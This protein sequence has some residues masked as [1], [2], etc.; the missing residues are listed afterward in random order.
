VACA[1]AAADGIPAPTGVGLTVASGDQT[2]LYGV[3]TYWDSVCVCGPLAERGLDVR[4]Y[5]QIAYWRGTQ[6]PSE[7]P[8]LWEGSVT[9][10]LRWMGPSVGAATV[11]AEIGLAFGGLSK[12]GSTKRRKLR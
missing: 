1:N 6:R 2:T 9:P 4:I 7:F 5:G 8:S 10:A 12:P 11:F 3:S